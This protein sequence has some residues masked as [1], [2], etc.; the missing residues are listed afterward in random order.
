[1]FAK[2]KLFV[3]LSLFVVGWLLWEPA[4]ACP[5]CQPSYFLAGLSVGGA[6]DSPEVSDRSGSQPG[7][8]PL[9]QIDSANKFAGNESLSQEASPVPSRAEPTL[10]A[11]PFKYVGN[12]F[13]SKFHRP[14][15]PFAKCISHCHLVYFARRY[16]AT[17]AGY[18]PCQYCL[19]RDWKTVHLVVLGHANGNSPVK[20]PQKSD[21]LTGQT[22]G[23]DQSQA[24][25][26]STK[27]P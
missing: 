9:L 11:L 22:E 13:S 7:S 19:P 23:L 25:A 5:G 27:D 6:N 16:N 2:S 26:G 21:D 14:S 20:P 1:M 17:D 24:Q 18:A 12:K 3:C 4:G 15:C 10:A 8:Q